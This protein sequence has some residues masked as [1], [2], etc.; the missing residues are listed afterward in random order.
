MHGLNGALTRL[1]GAAPFPGLPGHF[2]S[3]KTHARGLL[4]RQMSLG[5]ASHSLGQFGF[6]RP[7]DAGSEEQ[8]EGFPVHLT[9]HLHEHVEPFGFILDQRI[10]LPIGPQSDALFEPIHLVQMFLPALVYDAQEH[11]PLEMPQP[12]GTDPLLPALV[13]VSERGLQILFERVPFERTSVVVRKSYRKNLPQRPLQSL[14][15]PIFRVIGIEVL[16]EQ[17]VEGVADHPEHLVLQIV[18]LQHAPPPGIDHLPLLVH[19]VVVFQQV[20]AD[21]EVTA[22]HLLLRALDGTGD[23]RMGDHLAF[24]RAEAIHHTG[25][26]LRAEQAH[27]IVLEGN[28]ERRSPR[29]PLTRAPSPKLAVYPAGLV[30][31]RAD[32][33]KPARRVLPAVQRLEMGTRLSIRPL[34][35]GKRTIRVF[36]HARSQFDVRAPAGHIRGD[37]HGSGLTRH[38]NDLRLPLMVFCVEDFVFDPAPLEQAAQ[39]LG[40]FH[41][42]R[43]HQNRQVPLIEPR[44]LLDDRIVFLPLGAI[45]QIV[46]VHP[47]HGLVRGDHHHVQLVDLEQLS[48]LGLGRSRHARQFVVEPEEVLKRDRGQRLGLPLDGHALFGLQRLVKPIAEAPSRHQ[49]SGELIHDHHPALV[50][51]V[52][53]V[54]LEQGVGFEKLADIVHLL[55]LGRVLPVEF[56]ALL[57]LFFVWERF[58]LF[59]PLDFFAQIGKQKQ[60]LFA[61]GERLTPLFRQIH[62]MGFL[63]Y[64]EVKL[65][66]YLAQSLIPHK[67]RFH[68]GDELL[69]PLLLKELHQTFVLRRAPLRPEQLDSGLIPP[70]FV[71]QQLFS[72]RDQPVHERGLL[73]DQPIHER[74]H[75]VVPMRG[76]GHGPGDDQRRA[77]FV[78]EDEIHLIHNRVIIGTLHPILRAERA[79]IVPEVVEP[80]LVVRAV[81]DV[82]RVRDLSPGRIHFVLQTIHRQ[83]QVLI[84]PRHPFLI[85]ARQ[86]IVYGDEVHAPSRERVEVQGHGGDQRLSFARGHLRNLSLMQHDRSDHLHVV[87]NHVPRNLLPAD[88]PRLS[89]EAPADLLD[90][91]VGFGEDFVQNFLFPGLHGLLDVLLRLPR[92]GH[93]MPDRLA[94]LL[95]PIPELSGFRFQFLVRNGVQRFIELIDFLHN[96]LDFFEVPFVFVPEKFRD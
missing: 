95:D 89:H 42:D 76:F 58:V 55:A 78:D 54:L 60:I 44:D 11:R 62:G 51:H 39:D 6:P 85:A 29:I 81:G 74:L 12:L 13:F 14:Q 17:I 28:K 35:R 61:R 75:F 10:L 49:P 38:R 4:M 27:Q 82:R 15:V 26:A 59:D 77:R 8:L 80:K 63:V 50:D 31:L 34:V 96:R 93:P 48:G 7:D 32:D 16:L 41:R 21:V 53:H 33:V 25:D 22:L 18:L 84:D 92:L 71:L 3:A 83:S 20:L 45:D 30:P 40:D 67:I 88:H 70:L 87:R 47:A 2:P 66:V 52:S 24:L 65:L 68:S 1:I 91:R 72:L 9:E 23:H 46:V 37:G 79:V 19:H 64:G 73:S 43:T 57:D 86:I 69:D 94:L 90:H 5:L 36:H 56:V